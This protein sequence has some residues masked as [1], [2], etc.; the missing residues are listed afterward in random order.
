MKKILTNLKENWIT[1]GFETLVVIVGILIAF[2]LNN[3]NEGRKQRKLELNYLQR[4]HNDLVSDTIYYNRRYQQAMGVRVQNSKGLDMAYKELNSIDEVAE[5]FRTTRFP[6]EDLTIRDITYKEMM[7]AGHLNIIS[8]EKLK[9][10]ISDLYRQ[11]SIAQDHFEEINNTSI[12]L[13]IRWFDNAKSHKLIVKAVSSD[14]APYQPFMFEDDSEW[15]WLNDTKSD[16]FRQ[17]ENLLSLYVGKHDLFRGYL[18]DLKLRTKMILIRIEGILEAEGLEPI[19]Q[20]SQ[21]T[22]TE[23]R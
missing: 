18:D 8:N 15:A 16:E 6:S 14:Q 12:E 17:Y 19:N 3:W 13:M 9:I 5:L 1:Y 22:H 20:D 11:V 2:G 7:N 4:L 10:N 21:P 23:Q